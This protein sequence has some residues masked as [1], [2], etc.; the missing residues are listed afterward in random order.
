MAYSIECQD[1]RN[2]LLHRGRPLLRPLLRRHRGRRGPRAD[3]TTIVVAITTIIIMI[4][5]TPIYFPFFY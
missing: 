4:T 5:T 3:T 1:V 2:L